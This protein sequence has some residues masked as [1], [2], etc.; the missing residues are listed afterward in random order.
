MSKHNN[1]NPDYY[2]VAGRERQGHAVAK[3][4][5]QLGNRARAD[6]RWERS[7]QRVANQK[8]QKGSRTDKR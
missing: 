6:E 8:P 4:P 3:A 5:N 7:R 2:K 1:V